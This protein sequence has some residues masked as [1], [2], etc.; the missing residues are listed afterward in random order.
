MIG[1]ISVEMS[2]EMTQSIPSTVLQ[3]R[4]EYGIAESLLVRISV[5]RVKLCCQKVQVIYACVKRQLV[6]ETIE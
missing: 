2:V 3:E 5:E 4:L 1:Y 6:L